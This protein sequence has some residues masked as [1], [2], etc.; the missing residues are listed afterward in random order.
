MRLTLGKLPGI[1][2]YLARADDKWHNW[3]FEALTKEL[4]RWIDCNSLRLHPKADPKKE[5]LLHVSQLDSKTKIYVNCSWKGHKDN[6][7][8]KERDTRTQENF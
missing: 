7:C 6:E 2:S 4:S 5:Q 1:K 8:E 3:D